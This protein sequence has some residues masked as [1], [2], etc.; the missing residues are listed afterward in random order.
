MCFFAF[1]MKDVPEIEVPARY[2]T[3]VRYKELL[4]AMQLSIV[5]SITFPSYFLSFK[6]NAAGG[7]GKEI[8]SKF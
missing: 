6:V 2:L 4:C 8:A 5:N 1:P 7:F 3:S